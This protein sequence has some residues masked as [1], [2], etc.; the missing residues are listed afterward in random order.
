MLWIYQ[1]GLQDKLSVDEAKSA[2]LRTNYLEKMRTGTDECMAG[3]W[4]EGAVKG[5]SYL[6]NNSRVTD[7]CSGV[8]LLLNHVGRFFGDEELW[9]LQPS[10][11]TSAKFS[12]RYTEVFKANAQDIFNGHRE[13]MLRAT[14]NVSETAYR[15]GA[16]ALSLAEK[17]RDELATQAQNLVAHKQSAGEA[18]ERLATFQTLTRVGLYWTTIVGLGIVL[19]FARGAISLPSRARAS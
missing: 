4:P 8:S 15:F 18:A 2:T 10:L 3:I 6:E 7:A 12:K 14:G 11:Q 5:R 9:R 1:L 17:A 19:W 13:E 16:V